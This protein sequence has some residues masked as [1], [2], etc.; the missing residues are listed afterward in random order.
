MEIRG[1]VDGQPFDVSHCFTPDGKLV[2]CNSPNPMMRGI[3]V[4]L[5]AAAVNY[6]ILEPL[7]KLLCR[8]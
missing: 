3:G 1:D 2:T 8:K 7:G 5:L 6:G 4:G